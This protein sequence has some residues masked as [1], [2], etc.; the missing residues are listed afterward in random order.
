MRGTTSDGRRD[1]G[2]RRPPRRLA[3]STLRGL[4][5]ALRAFPEYLTDQRY[6]WTAI[7]ERE[8]GRRPV[9]A[10]DERNRIAHVTDFG[11]DPA[12]RPPSREEQVAFFEF[13][14]SQVRSRRALGR[15][16]T[17][18]ERDLASSNTVPRLALVNRLIGRSRYAAPLFGRR[19]MS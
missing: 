7:C 5:G 19:S 1:P 15:T 11:G 4:Q 14:D 10:I 8:F 2:G 3:V 13:C 18:A 9:Q 17:D 6:P 12:R 16:R